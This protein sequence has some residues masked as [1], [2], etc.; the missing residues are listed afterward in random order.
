MKKP[1]RN[2]I[3]ANMPGVFYGADPGFKGPA[4]PLLGIVC[5]DA[6]KADAAL[7]WLMRRAEILVIWTDGV[8]PGE[9]DKV[10]V[11]YRMKEKANCAGRHESGPPAGV[12]VQDVFDVKLDDEDGRG[13]SCRQV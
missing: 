4:D 3:V 1:K 13:R 10:H 12:E 7:R 2:M 6:Q 8:N 5:F 11:K 9:A